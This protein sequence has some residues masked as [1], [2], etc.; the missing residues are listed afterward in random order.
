MKAGYVARQPGLSGIKH[1]GCR[2]IQDVDTSMG[3]RTALTNISEETVRYG[4]SVGA[5]GLPH[6]Q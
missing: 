1:F 6:R 3:F 5:H 2:L 4:S